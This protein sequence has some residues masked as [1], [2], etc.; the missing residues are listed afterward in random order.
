MKHYIHHCSTQAEAPYLLL[1]SGLG[2]HANYWQPQLESL[3]QHFHVVT[4]DQEGCHRN[5]VL[6][7][8]DYQISDMAGQV[9]QVLEQLGITEFHFIGHALGGIIGIELAQLLQF[10]PAR[11][12]SLTLINAW[13]KLDPHTHKCFETRITLLTTAGA[14]AYVRAQALFLYPPAWISQ[15]HLQLKSTENRQLED[16][17]PTHNVLA[18]LNALMQFQL[19]TR[20]IKALRNTALHIVANQDDFLVPVHKAQDLF[21]Q[22]GHGQISILTTGAHASTV[23]EPHLLNHTL[24]QFFYKNRIL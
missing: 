23:T 20:H 15:N 5:T 18:R 7:S 22:L 24:I 4:Y 19:H 13:D 16:F 21:T 2:G 12:L 8:T 1:S 3:C 9:L 6:L 11:M 17:P 10:N 14:E